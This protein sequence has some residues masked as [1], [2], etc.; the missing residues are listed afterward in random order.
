M[1]ENSKNIKDGAPA[2]P[3]TIKPI[4]SYEKSFDYDEKMLPC[5]IRDN[6]SEP[7]FGEPTH[8]PGM[9]IRDYFAAHANAKDIEEILS[10]HAHYEMETFKYYKITPQQARFIHADRMLKAREE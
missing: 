2:F 6:L 8:I 3:T 9:S 7:I 1:S 4:I 10:E 5:N